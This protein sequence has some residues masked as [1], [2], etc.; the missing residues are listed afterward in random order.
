MV[1]QA[2]SNL[3][4][5]A[6]LLNVGFEE[7]M[8]DRNWTCAIFHDVDLLPEDDRNIYSCPEQ[9]RQPSFQYFDSICIFRHMSVAVDKFKYRLPYKML[10]GGASAIRSDQFRLEAE[11]ILR[12]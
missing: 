7:A 8:S 10:F 12:E 3:F 6:M 4:N 1:N 9:P 11:R 2:D 5:R